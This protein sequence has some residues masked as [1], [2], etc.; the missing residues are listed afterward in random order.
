MEVSV[1]MVILTQMEKN[2][3]IPKLIIIHFLVWENHNG[4]KEY[5]QIEKLKFFKM[6]AHHHNLKL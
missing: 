6:H 1:I 5:S 3:L 2:F 4:Y